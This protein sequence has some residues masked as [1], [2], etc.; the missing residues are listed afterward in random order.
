[1]HTIDNSL[2]SIT[3]SLFEG[4]LVR[5]VANDR[6]EIHVVARDLCAILGLDVRNVRRICD[7]EEVYTVRLLSSGGEQETIVLTESGMYQLIFQ[8]RKDVAVRFRK[9]IT[10]E[11]LPSIRRNGFYKVAGIDP[12]IARIHQGH[13]LAAQARQ[14]QL[15]A[16]ELQ[17]QA[18]AL[19]DFPDSATVQET[20]ISLGL[21]HTGQHLLKAANRMLHASRRL[22]I[23]QSSRR[24]G[25]RTYP[26]PAIISTLGL[27]QL[28]LTLDEA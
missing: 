25:A 3:S 8:S 22:G 28:T 5:L 1:M 11:V 2:S 26:R 23:P 19:L 21:P 9:W 16:D 10:G 7:S 14:L 4:H 24:S 27:D 6:N 15:R 20:L 17:A 18:E 13:Q 12:T